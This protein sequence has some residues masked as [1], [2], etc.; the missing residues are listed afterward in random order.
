MASKRDN[1]LRS[2]K[3]LLWE[4]GYEATSPRDIQKASGAGQGSFYHHFDSKLDLA[5]AA[6]DEVSAE[7]RAQ[8]TELF[9]DAL[10]GLERI[11]RFLLQQ[12]DGLKGC[13]LGRFA[14]EAVIGEAKVRAPIEAYFHHLQAA[15]T[16]AVTDARAGKE[17]AGA[18]APQDIAAAI[19]ATVQGG[20]ILS[21]VHK[22][23]NAINRATMTAMAMVRQALG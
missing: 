19:I 2:T 4:R 9:D 8:I 1:L 23:S 20:H 17:Q 15:L 13:K 7:M 14:M 3:K 10:P 21:R 11:E 18:P 5:A 22:D 16:Q 6:L 12:R